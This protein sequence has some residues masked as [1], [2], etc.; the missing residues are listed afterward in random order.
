MI[1]KIQ[2]FNP[3]FHSMSPEGFNARLNFL[4]QCT[5]QG[6]TYEA[7]SGNGIKTA[8]N[9]AF[10]R[11]P[12]CV[13]RIGDFINT[14]IIIN[15]ININYDNGGMQWDLN[16]EG[17][18]VQPM[19]ANISISFKFLGGQDITKP[20]ERLQN[21][22]TANYYANASVYSRHADNNKFYLLI[23]Y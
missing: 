14:R 7:K 6:H 22:V 19:Y 8:H 18:G 16:P 11:M 3:A 20:I 5:R 2:Y 13:L 10:G 9:L 12:V 23:L 4:H 1:R 15:N 21:A 17:I